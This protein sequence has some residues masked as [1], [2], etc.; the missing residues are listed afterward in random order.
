MHTRLT[1]L[2]VVAACSALTSVAHAASG[3][4]IVSTLCGACHEQTAT[5]WDRIDSVRKTPE[6]WDMTVRRMIH[7]FHIGGVSDDEIAAVVAYLSD[8]QGLSVAETQGRR[9]IL[10]R[11]PVA[12]DQGPTEQM[13]Q[14]C[15]RCHSYARVELQR[16]TPEDW[17]KL[18]H[19]HLGQFPTLEYQA[20]ARDRDWWG[21]AQSEI[22]PWLAEHYPLGQAP[23]PYAGDPAGDYIVAGHQPGRGDYRGTMTVTGPREGMEVTMALTYADGAQA[24]YT[25]RAHIL[26]A[27]EWR[28]TLGGADGD[29]HQVLAVGPDGRLDGRWFLA[30]QDV[31]GGRISAV[32]ADH[33]PVVLAAQPAMLRIGQPAEI[34]ISGTGLSDQ[35]TAPE[36]VTVDSVTQD[37]GGVTLTLAAAEP[38][39]IT[40]DIA[41]QP[42]ALVAYERLD[43]ISIIPDVAMSRIGGGGGA[44][45]KTPAQ[46]QAMGWLNGPDGQP[47]TDDDVAVGI[48]PAAWS[49]APWSGEAARMQDDKYA[50]VI[51]QTGLF[52]PA[53]AGPN[54]ERP[55]MTN[56]V[57]DLR[58]IATVEQDP[59]LTAEAHLYATVQR[60]VDA[61]IR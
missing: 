46:F 26:G 19:F 61:P 21:L 53:D 49:I 6:G 7:N 51:D 54:P 60:F 17:A 39:P 43:R 30:A 20:L 13:T 29:I 16:R 3:E 47:G 59:P 25:G 15:G 55:M 22:I 24:E 28:G 50:G 23:A 2:A 10:E 11:E 37:A 34:R 9:Y 35:V 31:T 52:T 36:G 40:L 32:R 57:G 12:S 42:V 8:T 45:P 4:E 56:N 27:G 44:I 14:T 38:G 1:T 5:G 48:V 58:V 41:G 18:V 33:P